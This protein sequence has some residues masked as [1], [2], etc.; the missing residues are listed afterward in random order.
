M[1]P[2]P[3]PLSPEVAG[4]ATSHK[5][6]GRDLRLGRKS[7]AHEN[8]KPASA[9]SLSWV[10]KVH[11]HSTLVGKQ[12]TTGTTNNQST[13]ANAV[14]KYSKASNLLSLILSSNSR[15]LQLGQSGRS[16]LVMIM[17]SL[18]AAALMHPRIPRA[19][20][21]LHVLSIALKNPRRM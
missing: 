19:H 6:L 11:G 1:A 3:A 21:C 8:E 15:P 12:V 5:G 7:N 18:A 17:Q 9:Q 20:H 2:L 10:S 16:V 13:H 4:R 14:R